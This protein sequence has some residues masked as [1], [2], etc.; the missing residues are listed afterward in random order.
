M[1][2]GR[3]A[4][5]GF[6]YIGILIAV[7]ILGVML[8]ST[9]VVWHTTEQR[10]RERELLY[11]GG[12][13]REAIGRYVDAAAAVSQYPASLEDLLR[14]PRQPG[15]VRYLRKIYYDPITGTQDWGLIKDVNDRII[16]VY[17][18]SQ[19]HPIKQRNFSQADQGFEGKDVYSDWTFIYTKP[20]FRRA[21]TRARVNPAAAAGTTPPPSSGTQQ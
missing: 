5:A 21:N 18:K 2:T 20:K 7:A 6:T 10:A 1:P 11:V 19:Q 3:H 15:V 8:A 13:I 16:G 12:Q 17:S 4:A 9:G 14:D